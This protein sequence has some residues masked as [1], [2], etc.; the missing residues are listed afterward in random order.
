MTDLTGQI[1]IDTKDILQLILYLVNSRLE[2]IETIPGSTTSGSTTTEKSN[3]DTTPVVPLVQG[4]PINDSLQH[5]RNLLEAFKD[6]KPEKLKKVLQEVN[7]GDK[8]SSYNE[9]LKSL[10]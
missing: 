3:P 10:I 1:T 9:L 7:E 5:I 2:K 4:V 6:T 8:T